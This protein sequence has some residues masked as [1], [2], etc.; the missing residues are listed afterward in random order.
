MIITKSG[1]FSANFEELS[2]SDYLTKIKKDANQKNLKVINVSSEINP[3]WQTLKRTKLRFLLRN[4]FR[5][6]LE[7]HSR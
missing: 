1:N 5:K 7:T 4:G 3:F 2:I 6:L